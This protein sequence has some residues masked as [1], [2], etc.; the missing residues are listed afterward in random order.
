[1]VLSLLGKDFSDYTVK[2][3]EKQILYPVKSFSAFPL[4][5]L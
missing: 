5:D 1:M 4:K 3:V 2:K